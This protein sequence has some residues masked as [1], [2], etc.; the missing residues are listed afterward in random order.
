MLNAS[1]IAR[2]AG[3][4]DG[5]IFA[6]KSPIFPAGVSRTGSEALRERVGIG[7]SVSARCDI[8]KC[9]SGWAFIGAADALFTGRALF[10]GAIIAADVVV[11]GTG[12]S[13]GCS[14][15]GNG[16][17]DG[18]AFKRIGSI[19]DGFLAVRAIGG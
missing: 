4:G 9:E 11:D 7:A 3:S 18:C 13:A 12:I 17:I 19:I 6:A 10:V 8:I 15:T 1:C 16:F 14:G 5:A 2:S